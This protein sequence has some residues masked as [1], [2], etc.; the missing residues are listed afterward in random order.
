MGDKKYKKLY[1]QIYA[2]SQWLYPVS[3]HIV[4]V[5]PD[6]TRPRNSVSDRI[7]ITTL[8]TKHLFGTLISDAQGK[9]ELKGTVAAT[10][11]HYD[12]GTIG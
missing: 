4:L 6:P 1:L 10:L 5:I 11:D 3:D 7:R 9:R 2:N 12:S 8:V